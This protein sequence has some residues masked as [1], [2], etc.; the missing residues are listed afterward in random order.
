MKHLFLTFAIVFAALSSTVSAQSENYTVIVSLDGF[1]WD[2]PRMYSTPNLDELARRGV[3]ATM[4]PSY[5]SSTFPN[6]YTLVT[7]LVPDHHGIVNNTFYDRASHRTYRISDTLTRNDPRYYGGEPIWRTAER[8]GVRAASIYW[9][10]SDIRT[11]RPT[12]YKEWADEP[13]L[14]F[15]GRIAQALEWLR[16]PE[17]ERPRL[18]TLYMEEPD[19][20]G[21]R[22]GPRGAETARTVSRQDSLIGVLA[23][24]IQS[25]PIGKKVNLIVTADHGMTDVSPERFIAVGDHLRPEW[26]HRVT[27]TNPTSIFA[28][29]GYCD[30][31]YNAL[32]GVPHLRVFRKG[33]IPASFN[34]G[35]HR[36][37]GDLI[38]VP[39][40]GWEFDFKPWTSV[41][42]HG[43]DVACEDM[44]VIFYAVGPDFRRG[45]R[46]E[47]FDNTAIY[48]L[49]SRLLG[50][51]PAPTDGNPA[52]I[53]QFLR[54]P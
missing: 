7:G 26:Y 20:A 27:G 32:T 9:I 4:R 48:S 2:Y 12:L 54:K 23:R 5:P 34:Y 36:N 15:E 33:D 41:G 25:L 40:A 1:R 22:S 8:Q 52:Q 18:I 16:L 46:G 35:T 28:S 50:I 6:H 42:A 39:D 43:F 11:L 45:F 21:H 47:A 3:S 10:G 51:T 38:V 14:T 49:L 17:S 31:I 37:I 30:S 44:H 19:G 53:V 13:R 24:G 29:P